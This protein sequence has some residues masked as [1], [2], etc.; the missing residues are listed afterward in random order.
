MP[1]EDAQ[2]VVHVTES[3]KHLVSLDTEDE[4]VSMSLR[5]GA[6]YG[7]VSSDNYGYVEMEVYVTI[8]LDDSTGDYYLDGAG[9]SVKTASGADVELENNIDISKGSYITISFIM[10]DEEVIITP[11]VAQYPKF[12]PTLTENAKK[13]FIFRE[14]MSSWSNEIDITQGLKEGTTVYVFLNGSDEIDTETSN[15]VLKVYLDSDPNELVREEY[16]FSGNNDWTSYQV[17]GEAYTVDLVI[18]PIEE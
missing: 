4:R 8:E 3:P 6:Q 15:Y 18:T 17:P 1:E 7:D 2:I 12:V 11:S 5:N 9:F 16:T 10:P 13:Y 14:G